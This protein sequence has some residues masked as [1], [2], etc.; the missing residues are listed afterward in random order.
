MRVRELADALD[1]TPDTVRYYTRIELLLP[2]RNTLNGYREYDEFQR[3]RLAFV[4]R[5]RSLGFTVGDVK[6]ILSEADKG[7]SACPLVRRLIKERLG[8]VEALYTQT[9][10][11]R[12]LM[13]RAIQEWNQLPDSEPTANTICHL[14]DHFDAGL[15]P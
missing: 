5:A 12:A 14:I 13:R 1:V 6:Q 15:E 11:R 2:T 7:A 9:A 3:R 8:E 4:L 10:A